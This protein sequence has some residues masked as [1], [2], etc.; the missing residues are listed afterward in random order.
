MKHLLTAI[1][2]LVTLMTVMVA[3]EDDNTTIGGSLV[4][5]KA[6]VVMD[7]S[8][9]LEGYSVV[10]SS[11]MSRSTT[12]LI[13]KI[14]A[15]GFGNFESSIVTQFMPGLTLDVS[16]F[17]TDDIDSVKFVMQMTNGCYTGDSVIPMGLKV[18]PLTKA[19]PSPIYS[20]FDPEGYYDPSDMWGSAVYA[21]NALGSSDSIKG[22]ASRKIEVMLPRSFAVKVYEYY[23]SNPEVFQSPQAFAKW[24]PGLYVA[25]SFGA[26]R[27]T[28]ID[29]SFITMYYHVH[30]KSEK[31]G[32]DTTIYY[33]NTY[34][35]V[36]PEI[37]TNNNISYDMSSSLSSRVDNGEALVVAPTG[38]DVAVRFPGREIVE[39]YRNTAGDIAML[40]ALNF[41]IPVEEIANDYGIT[42]PPYLLFVKTSQK[43]KFFADNKIDDG[44][45]SFYASYNS[46]TRKYVF[47]GM[48]TYIED[49]LKKSEIAD[50]DVDFT[51]TP[52]NLITETTQGSYAGAATTVVTGIVPYITNPVMARLLL[53]QAKIKLTFSKQ[54]VSL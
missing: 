20:N 13:G 22:L 1:F 42:P 11:V 29:K 21:A 37:V 30:D 12:Q 40:N 8:F 3:C 2:T 27:V 4:E 50:E 46:S 15:T 19:L 47:S 25:N 17:T 9:T 23:K 36:T 34:M 26:G 38:Y 14:N 6:E 35:A 39:K 52:V 5:D 44:V 18:Y 32:N 43:E 33:S 54:V 41:E 45:N 10:N 24:F 16:K 53:D 51:I 31:T 48:R 28:R 49:L 7:S